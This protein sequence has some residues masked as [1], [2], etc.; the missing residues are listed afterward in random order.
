MNVPI[1]NIVGFQKRDRQD[2]QNFNNGTFYRTPVTSAQCIISTE[3]NPDS[4]IL[5]N[6]H[7]EYRS[8]GYAQIKDSIL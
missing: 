5:M 4:P 8:R 7:D 3:E 6:Y 2:S 1:W